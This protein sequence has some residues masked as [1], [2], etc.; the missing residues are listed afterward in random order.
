[1]ENVG[2]DCKARFKQFFK[3]VESGE[4]KITTSCKFID[5]PSYPSDLLTRLYKEPGESA[6]LF[7]LRKRL[8]LIHHQLSQ[9]RY[10]ADSCFYLAES[11][12]ICYASI[13]AASM[14][15]LKLKC[16]P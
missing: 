15:L 3:Y 14:D 9:E 8:S 12:A 2:G 10:S 11:S 16:T 5:H 6:H 7:R 4:E 13:A 1:M